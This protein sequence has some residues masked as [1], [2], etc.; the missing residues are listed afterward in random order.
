MSLQIDG[1]ITVYKDTMVRVKHKINGLK[2]SRYYRNSEDDENST[3][4][5]TFTLNFPHDNDTV[6][7]AH[8]YPYTYRYELNLGVV[9]T[10]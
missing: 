1:F 9:N 6:Y 2:N 3:Y 7:F 10:L 8:C 4:S 5:L